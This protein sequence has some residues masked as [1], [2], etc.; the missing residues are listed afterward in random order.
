M[1][2]I[3]M[4]RDIRLDMQTSAAG[5]EDP[6]AAVD[7]PAA[8]GPAAYVSHTP[9][10][11]GSVCGKATEENLQ[12]PHERDQN[13]DMTGGKTQPV[14]QQ[15]ARLKRGLVDTDTRATPGLGA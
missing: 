10:T 3:K 4:K 5:E 12:L 13:R 8:S 14:I 1:K 7:A 6:G 15:A 11:P 9:G 2:S